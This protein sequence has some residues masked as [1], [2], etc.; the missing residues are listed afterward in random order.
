MRKD[1]G[2]QMF[3]RG[4]QG[5]SA[6]ESLQRPWGHTP[7]GEPPPHQPARIQLRASQGGEKGQRQGC[8]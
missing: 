8:S 5:D 7:L 4:R 6:E 2:P 1:R 3:P